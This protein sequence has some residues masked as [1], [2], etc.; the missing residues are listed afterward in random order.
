MNLRYLRKSNALAHAG[1]DSCRL[2]LGVQA[3]RS[4]DSR[5]ARTVGPPSW[6]HGFGHHENKTV[7]RA[8]LFLSAGPTSNL[9]PICST[10]ERTILIPN[11][12][13]A[14]RSKSVGKVG[15]S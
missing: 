7:N 15:P 1:Y 8:P 10:K 5:P 9:P 2:P 11:P 12:F 14:P 4:R 3:S 13:W 6:A